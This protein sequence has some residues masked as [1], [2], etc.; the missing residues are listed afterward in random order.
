MAFP[1]SFIDELLARNPIEEV[2]GQRVNLRRS[3]SN[4]FG[5]CPFHGEKT[6]SFS[7]APDKGIYYCFGC[8]KGGGAINF[9]MELEGLSYPDA[10][11]ALAQRSGLEVP[12]DEQYQSRYK[13]QERLW[14]LHKEAARFFHSQL[15]APIGK[16]AL[17]YAIGRGMTKS[18]LTKFGIGYAPDSWDMLVKAMEAKGYTRQELI[19]SGLVTVSQK[20][21]NTFDRFRDRLMFPIIDIRGNVIGFGGRIMNSNDPNAAKYLNSPETLIFN[22]RK[23]LFGLNYAKKTKLEYLI[24]VEGYMD[25]IALHQYGFD[26]AVA[27]LGTSLT[28]EHAVLISRYVEQV[29]LI[30]DGDEAG[31]RATRRAI[32]ILD[33]AGIR[34]KVLQ[35]RDAKDPDEYLKKFGAD[36]FRLLLEDSAN[37]VEYQLNAIRR[38]YDLKEDDQKIRYVHESAELISTLGSPIQREIYGG[39]VAEAAGIST[40][41]MKMEINKAYKNRVQREKKAQEKVDLAPVKTLQPKARSIRYDNMKSAMAEEGAI[42][43]ALADPSLMDKAKAL[44]GAVFSV[45]VLGKVYDQLLHMHQKGMEVTLGAITDLTPE[46][47]SHIVGICQRREGTVSEEAFTDCVKTILR[48]SQAE[49]VST[50][51][52]LMAFRNKLKESKGTNK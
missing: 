31:Q 47:M 40:E 4:L 9:V 1:P 52:D 49:K 15:Y 36:K 18:T 43:L 17:S 37:R 39:R 21:G 28:E 32:P 19:D 11:R 42:A 24:L 50:D 26:C 30:Y 2:V 51:D 38:K 16:N 14:A 35:M 29:V 20:N 7:V 22:K 6:A 27:S 33:K 13:A 3:G 46:E 5:L 10:V 45:P 25:A 12:E 8:H 48:I 41:A 44:S 23:N 34:V